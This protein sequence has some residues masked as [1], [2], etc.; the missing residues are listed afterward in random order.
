MRAGMPGVGPDDLKRWRRSLCERGQLDAEFAR[1]AAAAL[2][3]RLAAVATYDRGGCPKRREAKTR[4]FLS[5]LKRIVGEEPKSPG[6]MKGS[7]D[8]TADEGGKVDR[9]QRRGGLPPPVSP[10]A[11]GYPQRADGGR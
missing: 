4:A 11:A 6:K 8:W 3:N 1:D 10:R 5:K 2:E 7:G 9:R